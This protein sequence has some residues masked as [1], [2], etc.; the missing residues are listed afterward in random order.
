M[1]KALLFFTLFLC[2]ACVAAYFSAPYVLKHFASKALNDM[3]YE[4]VQ[5]S[6]LKI[7]LNAVSADKLQARSADGKLIIEELTAKYTLSFPY[8]EDIKIERLVAPYS[9]KDNNI[10]SASTPKLNPSIIPNIFIKDT[11]LKLNIKNSNYNK[12]YKLHECY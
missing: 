2:G 8:I 9:V 11:N 4:G 5:I 3:G 12:I 1:K 10:P 6:G 7:N